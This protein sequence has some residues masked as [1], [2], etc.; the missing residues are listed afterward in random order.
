[1]ETGTTDNANREIFPP[2]RRKRRHSARILRTET[3]PLRP[4]PG[5][6]RLSAENI[7]V[8]L[9]NEDYL[10]EREGA[11]LPGVNLV[12]PWDTPIDTPPLASDRCFS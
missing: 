9:A 12:N 4:A 1:M 7:R 3:K 5:Q 2:S 6:T 11:I 10:A 8:R